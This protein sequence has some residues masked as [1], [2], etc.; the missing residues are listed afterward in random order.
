MPAVDELQN[1]IPLPLLASPWLRRIGRVSFLG[2]LDRHPALKE[3]S[4]RLDHSK[5]VARL[6]ARVAR[7]LSLPTEERRVL[8]VASLLHDLGHY[9]LSHAAEP[10]FERALGAS[11]HELTRWI[12]LG[13]GPIARER[14]LRPLLDELDLPAEILW[15]LIDGR[16][17][18]AH[19][20]VAPLVAGRLSLDTLDGITRAA[21]A[22]GLQ[23]VKLPEPLFCLHDGEL[24]LRAEAV[25]AM[26]R[27]W[28]LKHR[29][30]ERVIHRPSN[31]LAE[32]KLC[33][34][35]PRLFDRR[36]L[37]ELESFDDEAFL[38]RLEEAGIDIPL[39]EAD[40]QALE[41]RFGVSRDVPA[42]RQTKRY[43][44]ERG[45]PVGPEGLPASCF[46]ERYVHVRDRAGLRPRPR[47]E[48][49]SHPDLLGE[50]R[51]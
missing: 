39:D 24:H 25:P 26:D 35:V 43:V 47:S 17:D 7:E 46:A 8:V 19:R 3:T 22:F 30:Y 44:L 50:P 11:H 42:H 40:D 6:A 31:V 21:R 5:A 2:A 29:V 1:V 45:R 10:G 14:S 41:L 32:A 13:D 23:S 28:Q 33:E 15:G 37:D 34:A 49:S 48:Q 27:F 38:A 36:L 16:P 51:S 12:V 20:H 4:T 9:P 18:D